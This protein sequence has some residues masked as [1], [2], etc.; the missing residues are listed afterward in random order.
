MGPGQKG[1]GKPIFAA[2]IFAPPPWV[3]VF[4]YMLYDFSTIFVVFPCFSMTSA[5]TIGFPGPF[6]PGPFWGLPKYMS[7]V[8]IV[9]ARPY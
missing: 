5:E 6:C 3:V 1:P 8:P 2:E 7:D 9:E 4:A